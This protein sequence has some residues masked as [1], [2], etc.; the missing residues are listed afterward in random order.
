MAHRGTQRQLRLLPF[1]TATVKNARDRM[2]AEELGSLFQ[3]FAILQPDENSILNFANR[4]GFLGVGEALIPVNGP[5]PKL[6]AQGE[7]MNLWFKEVHYF[8]CALQLFELVV[9]A[10]E[11]HGQRVLAKK[12][13]WRDTAILFPSECPTLG[14]ALDNGGIDGKIL[15]QIKKKSDAVVAGRLLLLDV[16]NRKLNAVSPRLFLDLAYDLHG[17]INPKNLL[18]LIWFQLYLGITQR[19]FKQCEICGEWMDTSTF[20]R[21]GS[22]RMHERCS[23]RKRMKAYRA[24]LASQA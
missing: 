5:A 9:A 13:V 8:R 20:E 4:Y 21:S 11:A 16:V 15:E 22:K 10:G 14:V 23:R 6:Q 17:Y 7:G 3:R 19:S 12:L 24:R 18:A 1:S 2:M